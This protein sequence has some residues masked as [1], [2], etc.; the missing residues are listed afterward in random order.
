M[1]ARNGKT[2][3]VTPRNVKGGTFTR[4]SSE[5]PRAV[6]KRGGSL[7][8]TSV[9]NRNLLSFLLL[10]VRSIT[11]G[12]RLRAVAAGPGRQFLSA[13]GASFCASPASAARAIPLFSTGT[14]RVWGLL[15]AQGRQYIEI[16][17]GS[18]GGGCGWRPPPASVFPGGPLPAGRVE[19]PRSS[20][21]GGETQ[22]HSK[23]SAP[24]PVREE[25]LA[26][27]SIDRA[28]DRSGVDRLTPS[29]RKASSGPGFSAGVFRW[30]RREARMSF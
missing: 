18:K 16:L 8:I 14:A 27:G 5:A 29:R 26:M 15:I 9:A 2:R 11:G 23:K 6:L 25:G 28:R 7:R 4:V 21:C 20:A 3:A 22:T 12:G 13:A 19:P 1:F 10:R 24:P 17:A 30:R